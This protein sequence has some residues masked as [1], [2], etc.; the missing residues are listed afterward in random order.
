MRYKGIKKLLISGAISLALATTVSGQTNK[1][2]AQTQVGNATPVTTPSSYFVNG[3]SPLV[4]YVR[5]RD[6]MG[7][8]ADTVLFA[9][10]GYADVKETTQFF[11]GLGRPLQTIQR[12]STPGSSPVDIVTPVIYDPFG[13]ETYKYLPFATTSGN[14]TDGGLKQDPFTDQKNFYQNVYPSEQ[15]AYAG[16]QVYYG[17]TIYEPSPLNRVTQILPPGNSWAGN[18]KGTTLRYFVNEVADSVVVW[19]IANDTLSNSNS[20]I[21]TNIPFPGGY[22]P[23][24]QLYKNVTLDEQNHAVVEYK[25][26]DGLVILKKVQNTGVAGDF[27]GYTGWLSTYYIYDYKNQLRFVLSPKATRIVL[28][29]GWNIPADTTAINELCFRYEYDGRRR[30]IAKKVPGAG[31]N[32]MVYDARDRLVYTQDANMGG[33]SQW[34]TTLYDVLN[35]PVTAGM[36]TYSGTRSQL[37][38]YVT[39]NTGNSTTSSVTVAGT[40]S[41]SLPQTRD[42]NTPGQDGDQKALN[43]IDWDPG[44]ETPDIVDFT[45]EIVTGGSTGAPFTNS[46]TVVDNPIPAGSNF[47][48]LTMTFYDDYSN[49]PDKSY[50]TKYNSL[51]DPGANVHVEAIP[52]ATDEQL[53]QTLGLV[54][55]TRTRVLEDPTDLT[56]GTWLSTA[57][58]YDDRA[59]VIQTQS[60]NYRGGQDTLTSLYNFTGQ[61][62]S[63]YLAHANPQAPVNGNTR[64]KTAMNYDASDRLLQVYK[65]I[66]DADSTKRLLAQHSFDQLGQLKQKQLGQ[67]L[68]G[69]FLETQD[70]AY[71]IRGWLKGINRDYTNNDNSHGGNDRW[72]GMDLS[73]DWGFGANQLNGNI[74]GNKWRSKGDGKQRAYGFGYD[75]ANRLLFSDFNQYASDWDK[76][77]G[78]DFSS[79]MGDGIHADSAY[80]DNGNIKAMKQLAWQLGGSKPIDDLHYAYSASSNKLQNVID[81]QNDPTTTLGDFRTSALS[82][83]NNNKTNSA[84]DYNY[85]VNGNLIRDL[86]KDIGSQTTDGIIYNHLNLPWRITVRSATGTKGTITYI[87]DA[88]GNKLQKNT[89]DSAGGLQTA[90]SYIGAFQYQGKKALGNPPA[91]T[92][93]F[94]GHEEGRVRVTTDTTG[95][96]STT[97]FK[98]D[99]FLKDHLGNTRMVLTDEQ[100][101]DR[102]PAATM[103]IGDSATENLYYTSLDTYRTL[104]PPG[105]PTD[106]TTNP[107]N[108]VAGL[109]SADGSQ[110]IGPAIVLKVMAGDKFSIRASS[111]YSLNAATPQTPVSPLTDIV[112]ALISGVGVL[113]GGGHPLPS[114]LQTNSSVLSGNVNTFLTTRTDTA[115]A[116]TGKPH[117]FVNWILFDNQFNYVE[118]SSGYSQVGADQELH[119]H[120]LTDLPVTSSGY[121][122]IYTSNQTPNVEVFFD[123]LQVTHTRGPLLEEDHY[124]PFGLTMAGISDKALKSN[125]AENKYRFQK[126]ELQN[127]EFSDGSGLEMY[128]FKYRFDDCQIGRFWSIDPLADKYVYNSPYAFSEDKVT[129]HVELEGLEAEYIFSKAKQELA[130]AFQG[131]ANAFDKAVSVFN[132]SSSSTEVQSGPL[133]TTTAGT[134]VTTTTSTNAGGNMSYIIT[135]NSNDG[136]PEPAT[137]TTVTVSADTKTTINT[138]VV[139]MSQKTSLDNNGVVTNET[140]A[141]G[142]IKVDG[143]PVAV[144]ASASTSTNGQTKVGIQG[145]V[146]TGNTQGVGQV[147]YSTKGNQQGVSIG[148]GVQQ[149][150]GS[151]TVSTIFGINLGW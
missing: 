118:S 5:E 107:N 37:Q 97:G 20:N 115:G 53:I 2:G 45:S 39:N 36:L 29:N 51:L 120:I 52:A 35:R 41:G 6:A 101:T 21:S 90:T 31:W 138:P 93:Q 140:A 109:S 82:P 125:Y 67:T 146:G 132:K 147:Q 28:G 13:R 30:M 26:K 117:A 84:I 105:Y 95:G 126:Q 44:F 61:V 102:Y 108:Y 47:V 43:E 85:D 121:L 139:Q 17:Q 68:A 92:L 99:Y 148:V 134:T 10:A 55:G 87:Y 34:M 9:S 83:Y 63:T 110:K 112:T 14:T 12:Q 22:Y 19:Y 60:D 135:H 151:T 66:N 74:A 23:A 88:A 24:G 78:V 71:N 129:T 75:A 100:E 143:V 62:L 65:T 8:I 113:P 33:H 81:G 25:D 4:N 50:A 133:T 91:D 48:A 119:P 11:D 70:Y 57:S 145:A 79:T 40:G 114:T 69:A 59:R 130:N 137:K 116:G 111:W 123:N 73:Y 122:Y 7:R 64:I 142:N 128:E 86:N 16:E 98:Y 76:T 104:L 141:K 96:Q 136:N 1:P 54:T 89:L 149:K 38:A 3:H 72:F 124:Y 18:G 27:S 131:L 46:L 144:T 15:P 49:S 42:L 77:A 80:D 106:T 127:K 94:F 103:E 32:Y 56:K 58:F 150:A